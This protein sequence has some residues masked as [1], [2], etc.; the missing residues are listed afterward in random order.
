[1]TWGSSVHCYA[2]ASG[3]CGLRA[4]LAGPCTASSTLPYERAATSSMSKASV[5][6][7]VCWQ[8]CHMS[9]HW[10]WY[11]ITSGIVVCHHSQS[12]RCCRWTLPATS[13]A[14]HT[15]VLSWFQ[16][17]LDDAPAKTDVAAAAG[18]FAGRAAAG[19]HGAHSRAPSA[20]DSVS[21]ARAAA[22]LKPAAGTFTW[23]Q[24]SILL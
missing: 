21:A 15:W 12:R 24:L 18:D 1:M 16:S 19:R 10:R 23:R 22:C 13:N 8:S 2:Q 4:T 7:S 6:R 14:S 11:C 5:A 9:L 20:G 17:A 3:F